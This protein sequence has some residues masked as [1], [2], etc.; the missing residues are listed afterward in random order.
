MTKERN[1]SISAEPEL[2]VA[3]RLNVLLEVIAVVRCIFGCFLD[4]NILYHVVTKTDE[5]TISEFLL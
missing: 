4:A 2:G 1:Y 5:M 3:L